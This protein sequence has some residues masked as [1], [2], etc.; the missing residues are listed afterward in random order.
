MYFVRS[1]HWRRWQGKRQYQPQTTSQLHLSL[2]CVLKSLLCALTPTV[3]EDSPYNFSRSRSRG[4][5]SGLRTS[6]SNHAN[7]T[8]R[9]SRIRA[10]VRKKSSS[11][12]VNVTSG[13]NYRDGISK[14]KQV[15]STPIILPKPKMTK[16][17]Q[18]MCSTSQT[19][20]HDNHV[21]SFS[22][23]NTICCVTS[24]SPSAG[25]TKPTVTSSN[26]SAAPNMYCRKDG[27]IV[28]DKGNVIHVHVLM[29]DHY[30]YG[31]PL[32]CR[33]YRKGFYS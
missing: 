1:R 26:I 15:Q 11:T 31:H 22:P 30:D 7:T 4:V 23:G 2:G 29:H 9:S 3:R 24:M 5:N 19:A 14:S 18:S 8:S 27:S 6:K 28:E 20:V 16:E 32:Y 25:Q 21:R 10:R 13:E 12:N 33:T 17:V